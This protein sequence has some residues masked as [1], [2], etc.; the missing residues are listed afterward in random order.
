MAV[1]EGEGR[2]TQ[3]PIAHTH[4]RARAYSNDLFAVYNATRAARE[5]C[6]REGRPV[7]VE[8]MTYRV[9]H[10][11]TSDDS[12]RCVCVYCVHCVCGWVSVCLPSRT[13]TSLSLAHTHTHK[14]HTNKHTK[15][16][17]PHT[18]PHT[19]TH[20]SYRSLAEIKQWQETDDPLARLRGYMEGQG[21]WSPEE[22]TQLRDA[23]RLAVLRAL[24]RAEA[25]PKPRVAELF[26]DVYASK[27]P[28][29]REQEQALHAHVAK[30]PEYYGGG[31][32][33]G[34]GG[35]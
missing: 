33:S 30:Y 4:T 15:H 22:E 11:S 13:D 1:R 28:H 5:V 18:Q 19:H 23:E 24:E 20:H 7:L 25:K 29:L 16:T 31:G 14:T 8:A 27:P 2:T 12:T 3:A 35:H 9:G 26:T 17:Q 34:T 32:G 10:H 21:W 6:V